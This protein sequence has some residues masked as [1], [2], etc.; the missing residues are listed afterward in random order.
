MS[1]VP[2]PAVEIHV[3]FAQEIDL[4]HD[5]GMEHVGAMIDNMNKFEP[6][7]FTLAAAA[8][9]KG[10]ALPDAALAKRARLASSVLEMDDEQ[11]EEHSDFEYAYA[12]NTLDFKGPFANSFESA[13]TKVLGAEH[14]LSIALL[15]VL[16]ENGSGLGY[17]SGP[18][19]LVDA[20]DMRMYVVHKETMLSPKYS[21]DQDP[22]YDDISVPGVWGSPN[23]LEIPV[24]KLD[25]KTV[26]EAMHRICRTFGL[27]MKGS[28]GWKLLVNTG[29]A[30]DEDSLF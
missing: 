9:P 12:V 14:G 7:L 10:S 3:A 24:D 13:T 28:A 25:A 2:K 16:D 26:K 30:V 21:E 1:R 29:T 17:Y 8:A 20:K 18:A 23:S 6:S 19:V 11:L 5:F 27:D 15:N 4:P 22:D